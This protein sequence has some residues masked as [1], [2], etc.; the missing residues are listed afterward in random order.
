[1]RC[2]LLQWDQA[3]DLANTLAPSRIPFISLQYAQ[4]LELMWVNPVATG[5]RQFQSPANSIT[6]LR[7]YSK[8]AFVCCSIYSNILWYKYC[9]LVTSVVIAFPYRGD[10]A[11]ALI[12]YNKAITASPEVSTTS[13][14]LQIYCS[15]SFP[16]PP[17][18]SFPPF[19]PPPLSLSLSLSLSLC[20][21]AC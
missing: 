8:V 5:T 12:H 10:H 11:N 15:P 16:L 21:S 4:Q 3:F 13:K 14:T 17:S 7:V 18:L 2:D 19:L 1:M 20:L 6:L 9:I